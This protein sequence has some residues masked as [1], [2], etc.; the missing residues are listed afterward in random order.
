[1][2]IYYQPSL[3]GA[4]V[5]TYDPGAVG[6]IALGEKVELHKTLEPEPSKSLGSM[7][8]RIREIG[9]MLLNLSVLQGLRSLAHTMGCHHPMAYL[10]LSLVCLLHQ[11]PSP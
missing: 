5:V 11:W 4:K 3:C 8:L 1:M 7:L 2:L 10:H 6:R 9:R